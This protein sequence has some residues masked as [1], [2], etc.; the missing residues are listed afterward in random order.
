[1]ATLTLFSLLCNLALATAHPP[2]DDLAAIG[3][4]SEQLQQQ[5]ESGSLYLQRAESH[6]RLGN[7]NLAQADIR[8][9]AA[10]TDITIQQAAKLLQARL[11]RRAG[12]GEAAV[13]SLTQLL[14]SDTPL[15]AALA[16]EAWLLKAVLALD[17]QAPGE[18]NRALTTALAHAR[19]ASAHALI[20]GVHLRR[21]ESDPDHSS[22]HGRQAWLAI[23][24]VS[25]PPQRSSLLANLGQRAAA[26]GDTATAYRAYSH[27]IP[28]ARRID[29]PRI[30]SR[31]AGALA[32]LYEQ[33]GRL[34]EALQLTWS[35]I[36]AAKGASDLLLDWEWQQGRLLKQEGKSGDALAAY[37]RAILH[38][39]RIRPDMPIDYS[40]GRSS[41]RDTLSPLY[42]ETISLLLSQAD[43]SQGEP[44]QKLLGE[45]QQ[46]ME[47]LKT[48]ELQDYFKDACAVTQSPLEDLEKIAPR[49]AILYPILFPDRV[50]MLIQLGGTKHHVT[51][52]VS[53][54]ELGLLGTRLLR[55][56]RPGPAGIRPFSTS[57]AGRLYRALMA[58][59]IPLLEEHKIETLVYLPDGIL[60]AI[61]I[62]ALWDGNAFLVERYAIAVAP[63]MTLLDPKPI[64]REGFVGLLAGLSTPGDVVERLP[65]SMRDALLQGTAG[66]GI[67]DGQQ[68]RA[69]N[70]RALPHP[71]ESPAPAPQEELTE[72]TLRNLQQ[73][74]ALPG[75]DEELNRLAE[76]MPAVRLQDETFLLDDFEK[77]IEESYRIVHIAS[78]GLFSGTPE[79][80]FIITYD[81]LLDMNHLEALFKSDSFTDSPVEILTLSACQTAEGDERS[82]LGLSGVAIKSGARS[83]V[84]SLWPV[85]DEAAQRLLPAFYRGLKDGG[86]SKAKALQQAKIELLRQKA[87]THPAL[88][89]PFILIGNWL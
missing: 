48:A 37:R 88:W 76:I 42:L 51:L 15:E 73:A 10:D 81:Q 39:D 45:A 36:A 49:T 43:T 19:E 9:A 5:P 85:A 56:L 7:L 22:Q 31:A 68:V 79:E 86:L 34:D 47:R 71:S 55:T 14:G 29:D 40:D 52:E 84:G 82:P 75:V 4:W 38:L 26:A 65:Q 12:D 30:L 61:P 28:L 8:T 24:A 44:R 18:A 74:L 54:A 32:Q 25:S 46:T 16:A 57:I 78:H 11:H 58:P 33:E 6:L 53:S 83:A 27:A 80:S 66:S 50:E 87:F 1:L 17:Q 35:A 77:A 2:A 72:A 60:R 69:L 23:D 67:P 62:D 13:A 59:V 21:M 41:F 89:S 63:G 70:L 64:P 3:Y 20:A